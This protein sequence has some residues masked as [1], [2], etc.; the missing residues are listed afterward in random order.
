[1]STPIA[2]LGI[3]DLASRLRDHDVPVLSEGGIAPTARA[4]RDRLTSGEDIAAVVLFDDPD[5]AF[6]PKWVRSAA[7]RVSGRVLV[8]HGPDHLVADDSLI[9]LDLPVSIAEVMTAIEFPVPDGL[10][11]WTVD[12]V[13]GTPSIL[14]PAEDPGDESTQDDD[15]WGIPDEDDSFD[16]A[17]LATSPSGNDVQSAIADE[18]VSPEVPDGQKPNNTPSEIEVPEEPVASGV[19]EVFIPSA[20]SAALPPSAS[21][22]SEEYSTT[23]GAVAPAGGSPLAPPDS[24]PETSG[25]SSSTRSST[26]SGSSVATPP[27]SPQDE[28]AWNM[29]DSVDR[30]PDA[31][32][33]DAAPQ[34]SANKAD[35]EPEDAVA[36]EPDTPG[37]HFPDTPSAP[38]EPIQSPS[39]PMEPETS[40]EDRIGYTPVYE[41]DMTP[42]HQP[43][44]HPDTPAPS[45][46]PQAQQPAPAAPEPA[47]FTTTVP[48]P[49]PALQPSP[50]PADQDDTGHQSALARRRAALV[51]TTPDTGTDLIETDKEAAHRRRRSLRTNQC[52]LIIVM[53]AKGGVG[54]TTLSVYTPAEAAD[55]GLKAALIDGSRGQA[56]ISTVLRIPSR[57]IPTMYEAVIDSP[58]S[59]IVTPAMLNGLRGDFL[60][61]LKHAVVFG[62]PPE[63]SSA[64]IVTADHYRQVI[65]AVR[66]QSD[67]VVIDTQIME[68]SDTSGIFDQAL[69]P[70]MREDAWVVTISDQSWTSLRNAKQRIKALIEE[71]VPQDRLL[72]V[73]NANKSVSDD[74][75]ERR[76]EL[77]TAI[78]LI[79]E[80]TRYIGHIPALPAIGWQMNN[81]D[82]S[83][84]PQ[85]LREVLH[86]ILHRVTG[87]DIP[88]PEPEKKGFLSR[89]FGGR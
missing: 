4:V 89:L 37:H 75:K 87:V 61:P 53:A 60:P 11:D 71:G 68:A 49:E 7:P 81:G 3:D 17:N 74:E 59:A 42:I 85:E 63:L 26:P 46:A 67:L 23:W 55:L 78:T 69:I 31:G 30:T 1:M 33:D 13:E 32:A 43:G 62:P 82:T 66:E 28:D 48:T 45:P 73:I 64:D 86:E 25:H 10:G 56:D 38:P 83:N 29:D 51:S 9:H 72:S 16:G 18:F 77:D 84:P 24:S 36:E 44:D 76:E 39:D 5:T 8:L 15:D 41:A 70:M 58:E 40:L 12:L 57:K 35:E 52:P 14:P 34:E 22:P 20:P 65:E 21:T 79:S 47:P 50:N 2:L 88:E 27:T 19:F 6:L 54:K 80:S